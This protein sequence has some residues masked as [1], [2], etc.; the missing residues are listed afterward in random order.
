MI[1]RH[2]YV[3]LQPDQRSRVVDDDDD[4]EEATLKYPTASAL[5]LLH[6]AATHDDRFSDSGSVDALNTPEV[7]PAT[8]Q[9]SA[10]LVVVN[11][12]DV[13]DK[14]IA[15]RWTSG[16]TMGWLLRLVTGAPLV[17]GGPDSSRVLSD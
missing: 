4:D 7:F 12:P 6:G 2:A 17:V 11:K 13:A 10:P 14:V 9:T 8:P 16:V 15:A 3:F 1:F 5:S